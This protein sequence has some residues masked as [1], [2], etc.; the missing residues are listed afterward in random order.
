[1]V[2]E[3]Q[4]GICYSVLI[5]K[6]RDFGEWDPLVPE[7]HLQLYPLGYTDRVKQWSGG[8]PPAQP[9][10]GVPHPFDSPPRLPPPHRAKSGR[11]GGPGSLGASAKQDRPPVEERA[12]E[13]R[14]WD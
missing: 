2:K 9:A 14:G 13:S 5:Y 11:A 8:W 6:H 12:D 10:P 1:V 4:Q 3:T 7:G